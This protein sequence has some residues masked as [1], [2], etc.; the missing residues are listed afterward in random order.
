MKIL[1]IGDASNVNNT[2]A[3]GL[4]ALGHKTLVVSDG[5]RWRDMKRDISLV[6]DYKLLGGTRYAAKLATLLPRFRNFDVVQIHN[7]LF[8]DLKASRIPYIYKY[9]RRHNR[10]VFMQALGDDW[11]WVNN[12]IKFLQLRYSDFNIGSKLR[13]DKC[14]VTQRREWLGTDKEKLSKMIAED[15]DGIIAGLYEYWACYDISLPKKTHFIPFPIKLQENLPSSFAVPKK[16]RIFIGLDMRRMQ[17]K[18]TD[19]MLKAAKDI[20][21]AYPDDVEL[22]VARNVPFAKY[23]EMMNGSDIILDQLYSYTPAMNALLAMSKGIVCVG[24]G[25]PEN[26]EI[27]GEHELQPIINVEPSYD[28]V[29]HALE[30]IIL[31]KDR[32]PMLKAQSIE[33]V[34]RHHDYIKVAKQYEQIYLGK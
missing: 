9:L 34:K 4:K 30:E 22:I 33:Y 2:L 32:L 25:E 10:K 29:Y 12:N 3:E 28:S 6:R 5:L 1:F 21:H 20:E 11:Y 7:P 14:A 26:Y 19:I 24:G 23:Q 13:D 27:I 16:V 8:V 18:G 17:Y 15:C 31:H